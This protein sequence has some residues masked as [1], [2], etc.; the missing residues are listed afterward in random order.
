[1]AN[2]DW[3]PLAIL[4]NIYANEAVE[5]G[6]VALAPWGDPRVRLYC[7]T[8]PKF[9]DLMSR[10]TNAFRVS[11]RPVVF[12]VREDARIKFRE[13]TALMSFV[14]LVAACVVPHARSRNLVYRNSS[15]GISY[16]NSFWLYPWMLD[17]QNEHLVTSTPAHTGFHVVEEFYGQS[18]PE[19]SEMQLTD[20]D[21]PLFKELLKRWKR[22]YLG[23]R[24]RWQDRALFRSLNMAFQAAQ[25]P[26]GVGVT[27]Y[28][29]GRIAALWVSAF[30]ILA[31]PRIGKSDLFRV[32]GILEK[33]SYLD[34]NVGRFSYAA[35]NGGRKP[36]PRRPL[37]CWLY[38]ELY[39]ARNKFL[40]GNPIGSNVLKPKKIKVS[41][42]WL[43][44]SLY[45]LA[46]SGALGLKFRRK[47]SKSASAEWLGGYAS[48]QMTFD[49]PQALAE[50]ALLRAIKPSPP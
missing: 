16:S 17:N 15:I 40:H 36:V 1:M 2:P 14:D 32:Y 48:A 38:G 20:I 6:V 12:I 35:N 33:V 26:A 28:D 29:L 50:R 43:A 37:P 22:H 19:L 27:L 34:G 39:R 46:L 8:H 21:V 3:V 7:Q 25:L 11:L 31:H 10:F 42:F 13:N 24:Q 41:L 45:R 49:D 23:S 5:G 44:P 30:E 18:S 9:N 4:P 47:I